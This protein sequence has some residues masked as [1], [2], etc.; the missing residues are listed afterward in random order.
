MIVVN[1]DSSSLPD[2]EQSGRVG[3]FLQ[4]EVA[5]RSIRPHERIFFR[6]DFFISFSIDRN[7]R[8]NY[9]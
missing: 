6:E 5:T 8:F 7:G 9:I 2:A 3:G 1:D 4:L